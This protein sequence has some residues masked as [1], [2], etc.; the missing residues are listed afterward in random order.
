MR[1][2]RLTVILLAA[3]LLVSSAGCKTEPKS[4]TNDKE[5]NNLSGTITVW[6]YG[7][8]AKGLKDAA[9]S[10]KEKHPNV[11]VNVVEFNS[12]ELK[13]KLIE[14]ISTK[15]SEPDIVNINEE[16][17]ADILKNYMDNFQVLSDESALPQ[18]DRF[19]K[20]YV[21]ASTIKNK[22]YALPYDTE[23]VLMYYRRDIFNNLGVKIEDIKTWEDF[24]D[25]GRRLKISSEDKIRLM[26]VEINKSDVFLRILVSQLNS[27]YPSE[28][29]NYEISKTSYTKAMSLIRQI[30]SLKLAQPVASLEEAVNSIKNGTVAAVAAGSNFSG[31]LQESFPEQRGKWGVIRLPAFE[32]GGSTS[33]VINGSYLALLGK[34]QNKNVALEFMSYASSEGKVLENGLSKYG[35]FPSYIP[36]Y[37]EVVFD[38]SSSYFSNEK[39][40]RLYNNVV[41]NSSGIT[42][43]FD[44]EKAKQQ[45]IKA[46][47]KVSLTDEDILNIIKDIKKQ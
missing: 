27:E 29:K 18:K 26:P 14:S 46:Q 47:E 7:F 34:T 28:E 12:S 23:P 24:I 15:T 22:V 44:Y 20:K 37:D 40:F 38:S 16:A 33:A 6:S 30:N 5:K 35:I 45:I 11:T 3:F 19:L 36:F 31:F 25:I 32:P 42:Y 4:E 41:E 17:I 1:I 13:E 2:K 39:L 10:F 21:L 9:A 43:Y 8:K